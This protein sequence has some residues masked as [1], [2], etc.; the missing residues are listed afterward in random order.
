[1]PTRT[2]T[3]FFGRLNVTAYNADKKELILKGL[4]TDKFHDKNEFRYGFFDVEELNDTFAFGRLVKYK[5]LLE[6]EIVNEES[7]RTALGALPYGMVGKSDFFLH[8][9]S[10]VVAYRP[11]ASRISARQF[12]FVFAR[13]IEVA[14]DNFFVN[15]QVETI[16]EGLKIEEAFRKLEVIRRVSFDIHPTNPSNREVYKRVDER[17]KQLRAEKLR[18]VV[19]AGEGGLNKKALLEDDIYKSLIMAGDGYGSGSIHG[20]AEGRKMV[21]TTGDSPV[22]KEIVESQ[23]TSEMLENLLPAFKLIWERMK[24]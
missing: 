23:S 18:Q 11:V 10:G 16:D 24:E 1:M 21:I 13:L 15:A 19:E 7:H 12:R 8:Y 6:G 22:R 14:H 5:R 2:V 20:F 17:L 9:K 4:R 3:F